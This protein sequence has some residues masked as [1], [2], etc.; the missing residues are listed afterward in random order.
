MLHLSGSNFE[1][2][3]L[4]QTNHLILKSTIAQLLNIDPGLLKQS[5]QNP[6]EHDNP[7]YDERYDESRG[8]TL[9]CNRLQQIVTTYC[10]SK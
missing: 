10:K 6:Q 7:L 9:G 2:G 8:H 3:L 5:H 1:P 4:K